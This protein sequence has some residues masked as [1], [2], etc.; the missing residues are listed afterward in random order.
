M[1][2]KS[3][4]NTLGL[5]VVIF[6]LVFVGCCSK[7]DTDSNKEQTGSNS[8]STE[9]TSDEN[10]GS[11]DSTEN[12]VLDGELSVI[13]DNIYEKKD[14]TLMLASTPLDLTNMDSVIY[15][16][17]LADIS[18]V[19]EAI[20]SEAMISS[21]AYSLVLI[22][23]SDA[24]YAEEVANSMKNG[25]NQSKWICVTAD[26]LQIATQDDL[27]LLVMVSS[28]LKDSVTS[29]QMIEAFQAVAGDELDLIL[30]K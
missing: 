7:T 11:N 30:T 26:D 8:S 3:I 4:R 23:V 16:T 21:Q 29:Q 17:G 12:D 27:V 24:A 6:V 19:K 2:L 28:E 13:I 25:I 10:L 5:V 20:V 18:K 14:T 15:N 9:E 1:N 22:R